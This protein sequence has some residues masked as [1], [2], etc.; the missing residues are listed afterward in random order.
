MK[1]KKRYIVACVLLCIMSLVLSAGIFYI[2]TDLARYTKLNRTVSESW[3]STEYFVTKAYDSSEINKDAEM[4][5]NYIGTKTLVDGKYDAY[6][7]SRYGTGLIVNQEA[8]LGDRLTVYFKPD[9]PDL[10]Y[11]KV[12][13]T[14]YFIIVIGLFVLDIV[15]VILSLV[16]SKKLKEN[17]FSDS[18]VTIMNIP[19]AVLIIGVILGF[20]SGMLMGNLQ[21]GTKYTEINT[22]IAQ[23]YESHELT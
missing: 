6:G 23:Q 21:V 19:I 12:S 14:Q 3:I 13:Y 5:Y 2:E 8:K 11:A 4:N 16:L 22:A 15:L 18:P 9:N 17:T 20:F 10:E 7:I 1:I